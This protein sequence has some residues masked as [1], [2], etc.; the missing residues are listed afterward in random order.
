MIK[1]ERKTIYGCLKRIHRNITAMD[2]LDRKRERRRI[3][4]MI[5][6]VDL[7]ELMGFSKDFKKLP[8]RICPGGRL[9]AAEILDKDKGKLLRICPGGRL[10][11]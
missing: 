6:L 11:A 10:P 4:V 1:Q 9:P 2:G 3:E 7:I 8:V 5:G